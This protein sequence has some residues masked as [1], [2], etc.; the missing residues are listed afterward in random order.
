[1]AAC[2]GRAADKNGHEFARK[3][4]KRFDGL[5]WKTKREVRLTRF[6]GGQSL[7]DVDVL[8]WQSATG[9]VYAVECK[10]LRCDRTCGEIGERLKEY[11]AG[12]VDG[13]R[14]S[15]QR[16]V[17]RVSF[18]EGQPSAACGLHRCS[19]RPTAV[20]VGA[21]DGATRSDAVSWHGGRGV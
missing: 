10:S 16:H 4:A 15:L 5:K 9:L 21:G 2:I 13:K 19:R 11:S 1:M 3:V 8:A 18:L 7:G 12:T 6:G 20:A 14:T 17:E